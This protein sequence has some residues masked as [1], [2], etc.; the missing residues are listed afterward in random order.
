VVVRDNG[1]GSLV[2]ATTEYNFDWLPY[3]HEP[4][5]PVLKKKA[6]ALAAGKTNHQAHA[7]FLR[8]AWR[9]LQEHPAR[10]LKRVLKANFW[11]WIESPGAYIT[12]ALRPLRW[13]T[14]GFHQLQ[15]LALLVGLWSLWRSGRLR[16]WA[17]WI[18][19]IVYFAVFLCLMMPIP[20]YYVPLLPVVD[21][22]IAAGLV[23]LLTQRDRRALPGA[24]PPGGT[25]ERASPA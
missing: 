7:A 8:A 21:A 3:P 6:D 23:S 4:G 25:A 14:L 5:W 11:F 10:V 19:T 24:V 13:L 17:L 15:L 20:R 18:A 22:L 12:G 2:W 1:F 16:V 9:N